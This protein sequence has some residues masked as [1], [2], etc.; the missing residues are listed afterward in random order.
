MSARRP[1]RDLLV[2]AAGALL[3]LGLVTLG[4]HLDA[5]AEAHL[6]GQQIAD[7]FAAGQRDGMRRVRCW[8]GIRVD[9]RDGRPLDLPA[10]R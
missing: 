4:Q 1:V 8:G 5:A 6:Q 9:A 3:M 2:G 7:A 10:P